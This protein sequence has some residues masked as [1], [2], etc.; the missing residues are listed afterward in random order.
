MFANKQNT[1]LIIQGPVN[2]S[3]EEYA[4][5]H[6]FNWV[7]TLPASFEQFDTVILSS[8]DVNGMSKDD[9]A[10][11][12]SDVFKSF[13][14]DEKTLAYLKEK[15]RTNFKAVLSTMPPPS[16]DDRFIYLPDGTTFYYAC[17]TT[18]KGI[19]H[20]KTPFFVK[21]RTDECYENYKPLLDAFN[22]NPYK[23][24]CGNIF[25]KKMHRGLPGHIGDHV[26]VGWTKKFEN[27]LGSLLCL[28]VKSSLEKI[29]NPIKDQ[30]WWK[31]LPKYTT[32]PIPEKILWK[33]WLWF[34]DVPPDLWHQ[35]DDSGEYPIARTIEVVDI[36]DMGFYIARWG[37]ANKTFHPQ[38]NPFNQ[39][40]FERI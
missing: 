26:Y 6:T 8:Y 17:Y 38:L 35:K 27:V 23:F 36:N 13:F 29:D 5:D 11:K 10:T 1:T 7:R 12:L 4:S 32:E 2:F 28:Y 31:M 25:F 19:E 34:S 18:F 33:T 15:V 24:V 3:T 14:P 9:L 40:H 39:H 37:H 21:A 16:S 22:S 30:S 20:C